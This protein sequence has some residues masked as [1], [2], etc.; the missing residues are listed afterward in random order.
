MQSCNIRIFRKLHNSEYGFDIP[1][2][3]EAVT[4]RLKFMLV[5]VRGNGWQTNN[6]SCK[7][8]K[9]EICRNIEIIKT[10]NTSWQK[11]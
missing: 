6:K 10:V 2:V 4:S 7:I 1:S 8:I 11:K 3:S 5:C 9:V